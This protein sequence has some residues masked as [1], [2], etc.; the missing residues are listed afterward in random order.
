[1]SA[2]SLARGPQPGEAVGANGAV[3]GW[4]GLIKVDGASYTWMGQPKIG[5]DFPTNV[6]QTSFEYTSQRSTFIMNVAGKVSMNV[7]FISPIAPKDLKRQSIIGSYL[8]V[9][10]A[11]TDGATHSVQLYAD[12]T[13]GTYQYLF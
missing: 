4:T 13:A 3:T 2:D 6:E 11:A 10:V 8:Q 5:D 12:T 1:M 7:T 9:T